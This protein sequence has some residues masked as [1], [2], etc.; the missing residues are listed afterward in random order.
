VAFAVYA[1]VVVFL[2]VTGAVGYLLD[3]IG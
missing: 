1:T 3:R 2:V